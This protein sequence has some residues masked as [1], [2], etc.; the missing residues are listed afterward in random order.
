[1]TKKKQTADKFA[2]IAMPKKIVDRMEDETL[3]T[4]KYELGGEGSGNAALAKIAR[5]TAESMGATW[6]QK[7]E[8]AILSAFAAMAR[9]GSLEVQRRSNL[10]LNSEQE[11][12]YARL[13]QWW[14]WLGEENQKRLAMKAHELSFM[15]YDLTKYI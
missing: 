12:E 6:Q 2:S 1:M 9:L 15:V 11:Q 10:I 14:N 5:E 4:M 8:A 3:G 13:M 7:H